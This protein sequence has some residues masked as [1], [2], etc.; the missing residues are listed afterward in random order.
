EIPGLL[1][2]DRVKPY[3]MINIIERLVDD[4]VFDEY[5]ALYGKTL[6]CGTARIDGWAV[7]IIANQRKVVKPRKGEMHMGGVIYSDAAD[8]SA[9]FIMNCNLRKI[10]LVFFQVVHG[11]IAGSKHE[12]GR[13]IKDSAKMVNAMEN[14]TVPKFT[15]I[16]SNSYG[17]GNS[18]MCGKAYHP[19]LIV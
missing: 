1:P 9:G 15:V 12:H 7:G 13:V 18:A 8:K 3:D 2:A 5:K 10:L 11:F 16:I 4:S 6:I 19:R 17:A 14:S